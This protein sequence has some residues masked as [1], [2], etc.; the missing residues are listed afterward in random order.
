MFG[1][2]FFSLFSERLVCWEADCSDGFPASG[3]CAGGA[4]GSGGVCC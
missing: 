3:V 4:H 2:G 1:A